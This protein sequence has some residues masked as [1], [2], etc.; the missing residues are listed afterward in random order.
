MSYGQNCETAEAE[1]G[2]GGCT[3]C[4]GGCT[5]PG[6]SGDGGAVVPPWGPV[7]PLLSRKFT[8]LGTG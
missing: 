4:E 2:R 6:V 3:A 8:D 5:I 1:S 7:V